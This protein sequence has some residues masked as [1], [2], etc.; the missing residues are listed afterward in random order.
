MMRF[1]LHHHGAQRRLAVEPE[2]LCM[3]TLQGAGGGLRAL[4]G[5]LAAQVAAQEHRACFVDV[6][7][8]LHRCTVAQREE[9]AQRSVTR[10]QVAQGVFQRLDLQLAAQVQH[11]G[12][13]VGGAVGLQLPGQP[14]ALLGLGQWKLALP[15]HAG[16]H[17]R[18]LRAGLEQR[19]DLRRA[20]RQRR[21]GEQHGRRELH[22]PA[23]HHR[24]HHLHGRQR[25]AA[26][27]EEV[28][29]P[30]SYGALERALPDRRQRGFDVAL[31]R[32]GEQLPALRIAG[33]GLELA[34]LDDGPGIQFA[35]APAAAA[36]AALQLAAGGLGQAAR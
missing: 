7:H 10:G 8:L 4:V 19:C 14:Q 11:A 32:L 15:V 34:L 30:A 25:V 12:Q 23:I 20:G 13:V 6:Q 18:G 16:W 27:A 22:L 2:G 29:L 9:S 33:S 26:A 35:I 21:R 28:G 24:R 1:Q 31:R 5:G 3:E 36:G 17:G